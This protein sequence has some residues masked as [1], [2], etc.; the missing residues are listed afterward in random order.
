M[1]ML[2]NKVTFLQDNI[3]P[4]RA[5]VTFQ[6]ISC[7]TGNALP[8]YNSSLTLCLRASTSLD[9]GRSSWKDNTSNMITGWKP[10]CTDWSDILLAGVIHGVVS[11]GQMPWLLWWLCGEIE[12]FL[13][14]TCVKVI[15]TYSS[16]LHAIWCLYHATWAYLSDALLNSVHK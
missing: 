3:C 15:N 11:Q 8:L 9:H 6:L 7:F 10:Q 1:T 5:C 2:T 16:S 14:V 4:H 13:A 12:G